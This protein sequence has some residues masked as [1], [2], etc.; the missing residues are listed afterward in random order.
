MVRKEM[1]R[2]LLMRNEWSMSSI[3]TVLLKRCNDVP[4]N[5]NAGMGSFCV[6]ALLW[7]LGNVN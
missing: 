7:R 6:Q 3:R 5:G 4:M 2:A 1:L